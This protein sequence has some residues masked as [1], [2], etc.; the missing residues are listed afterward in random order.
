MW[1]FS[2]LYFRQPLLIHV[3][4]RRDLSSFFDDN[5]LIKYSKRSTSCQVLPLHTSFAELEWTSWII[6]PSAYEM[7]ICS[8]ICH[9]NAKK[10]SCFTM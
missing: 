6:E 1:F 7:K 9:A 8:G 5:Q 2:T 4:I 10:S 3:I